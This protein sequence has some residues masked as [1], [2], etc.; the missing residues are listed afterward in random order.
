[1][2]TIIVKQ[3]CTPFY[4]ALFLHFSYAQFFLTSLFYFIS[5]PSLFF[6]FG[7][8]AVSSSDSFYPSQ[9]FCT[10]HT[11][12]NSLKIKNQHSS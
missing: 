8:L 11:C 1:M 3:S 4:L 12:E 5:V 6:N 9:G 10:Q 7:F 2:R